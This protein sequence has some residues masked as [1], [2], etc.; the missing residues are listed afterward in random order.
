MALTEAE[1]SRLEGH[2]KIAIVMNASTFQDAEDI[3][4]TV[5]IEESSG[6]IANPY[7]LRPTSTLEVIVGGWFNFGSNRMAI[8]SP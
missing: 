5:T 4:F 1:R 8:S 3:R 6:A 7:G 2:R